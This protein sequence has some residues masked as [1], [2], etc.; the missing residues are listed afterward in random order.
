MEWRF[1]LAVACIGGLSILLPV[2][3]PLSTRVAVEQSSSL[4]SEQELQPLAESITVKVLAEG[5]LGSGIIFKEKD[6]VYT[7]V[8]NAHVMI[9]GDPPYKIQT[10]DRRV[11]EAK[12][13]HQVKKLDATCFNG[14]DL[15]IL[16]FYSPTHKYAVA[17]LGSTSNLSVGNQV[18]AAG[19]PF[20]VEGTQDVGFVFKAGKV[21]WVLDKALDG[22][23][24]IGYTNDIQKGMSGGP[25]LNRQGKVVAIN[26]IHAEP[27]WGEP[28]TYQDGTPP[29][30]PLRQ[31][32]SKYSW[33]IPIETI[34][35][36]EPSSLKD[37]NSKFSFTYKCDRKHLQ[38]PQAVLPVSSLSIFT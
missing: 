21:S 33:G 36:L 35:E 4:G 23:Y 14:K 27:L 6:S 29:E 28:Y 13:P 15:A 38:K 11:Y 30:A 10:P 22:G 9:S 8:T 31:R 1:L 18:F 12:L 20:N 37:G 3:V 19:F 24:S 25:L 7:V 2:T 16:Q 32:M 5:F 17:S 26:G 34:V